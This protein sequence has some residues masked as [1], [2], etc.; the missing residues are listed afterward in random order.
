MRDTG[1]G[2]TW[3]RVPMAAAAAGVGGAGALRV[4][5]PLQQAAGGQ[6]GLPSPQ[7]PPGHSLRSGAPVNPGGDKSWEWLTAKAAVNKK[8]E[9]ARLKPPPSRGQGSVFAPVAWSSPGATG[10]PGP[11]P[12][13][14]RSGRGLAKPRGHCHSWV[15]SIWECCFIADTGTSLAPTS[16]GVGHHASFLF[17]CAPSPSPC[18]RI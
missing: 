3:A 18:G 10:S 2:G 6:R 5:P 14:G 15:P 17:P 12:V 13:S 9:G 7:R 8:T 11:G 1:A 16:H 4:A